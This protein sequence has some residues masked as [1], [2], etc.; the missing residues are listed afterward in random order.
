MKRKTFLSI[1]SLIALGVGIFALAFPAALLE[2]KGVAANAGA[3][4]WV[5]QVGLLLI[6]LGVT[7]FLVRGDEDSPTLKALFI[8]NIIVQLGLFPIEPLAYLNGVVT[9]VEGIIPNTLLHL[10]LAGGFAWY[11]MEMKS[12]K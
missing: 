4:V 3:N 11:L 8:G 2:S 7:A 1:A 9:K 12:K 5:R 10:V 6:A